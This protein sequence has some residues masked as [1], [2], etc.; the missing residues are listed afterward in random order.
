MTPRRKY[1]GV[2]GV[3]DFEVQEFFPKRS[4]YCLLIPVFNE[5]GKLEPELERAKRFGI[6]ELVDIFILDGGSNDGCTEEKTLQKEGVSTLLVKTGAG[7]Q[8]AQLRMGFYYALERGYDGVITVDGNNKD[9]VESVPLFIERLEEGYDFV[10]GSRYIA[11]GKAENT[12]FYRYI[13]VKWIHAPLV[14]KAA[15]EKFTDTTNAFRGYSK[16]YLK[17]P[18][19]QIFREIFSGYELLAYLSIRAAQLDLKTTEV[20]VE[21]RYPKAGKT[22]TKISPVK[23]SANLLGILLKAVH[24]RYNP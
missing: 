22:P 24:G 14:S 11:G 10:Q 20:P 6:D 9:S 15:G 19:V 16:R 5:H 8:G 4:R 23:G 17:H 7:K 13:A 21:R 12:P 3:P 18:D 1:S 2:G